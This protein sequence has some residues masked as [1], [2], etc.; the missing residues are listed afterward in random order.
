[1]KENSLVSHILAMVQWTNCG[2]PKTVLRSLR[3]TDPFG[4]ENAGRSRY[5][6]Y[7]LTSRRPEHAALFGCLSDIRWGELK[8][9]LSQNDVVSV[10]IMAHLPEFGTRLPS[11]APFWR[12]HYSMAKCAY[13]GAETTVFFLWMPICDACDLLLRKGKL[14]PK[15]PS[16]KAE[17]KASAKKTEDPVHE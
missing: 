12:R 2:Q 10:T 8:K 17:I 3:N 1:M 16:D 13:C 6:L 9:A 11:A 14:L 5:Q 4:R 7:S 15:R